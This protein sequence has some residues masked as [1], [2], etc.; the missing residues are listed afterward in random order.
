MENFTDAKPIVIQLTD[1]EIKLIKIVENELLVVT[2]NQPKEIQFY[3]L[4][5]CQ[6]KCS[7]TTINEIYAIEY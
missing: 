7:I 6:Y 3:D 2:V 4:T 5:T 1:S